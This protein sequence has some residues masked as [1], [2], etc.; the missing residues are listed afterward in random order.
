MERYSKSIYGDSRMRTFGKKQ[1]SPAD[2][3]GRASS[4]AEKSAGQDSWFRKNWCVLTLIA[5]VVVA[6]LLRFCFAYGISAGDNYALSGGSSAAS[7]RRIIAEILWGTYNPGNE[8]AL[9]Y[10]YGAESIYGPLF[11]Y[12]CAAW[13][14][15][16]SAFG[17]SYDASAGAALAW[18]PPIFGALT[19]IPV[20]ML[21]TKIFKGD[22]VIGLTAAG[23]YCLF[24]ALIMTSPFS[25]GTELPFL[26]FLVAGLTYFVVSA[27]SAVDELGVTGIK[28][29]FTTKAVLMWVLLAALFMVFIVLTWTG[30]WAIMMV[31]AIMLFFALL[32]ARL[33]GRPFGAVVGVAS[34]VLLAG[35]VAG[36][37]YYIPY[38]MWDSVFSG[39]CLVGVLAVAYSILF[40]ALEKKPWVLSIPLTCVVILAV[41]VVLYFVAPEL[42]DAALSG[43]DVY[44]GSLMSSLA[45]ETSRTSISAMAS[46]Y[47][48]LTLW[49]PLILG[50]WMFYKYR[51]N[52]RSNTYTFT[53]LWLLACYCVGWYNSEYA[54]VAGAGFAV[55]SAALI[56][57]VFRAV[58]LKSYFRSLRGNG[59][60]AGAKKA[61]NFFP[62]VT[63]LVAVLLVAVPTAVYAADA[64]TPSNDDGDGYFGG[65]G[66]TINTSDSSLVNSA[67]AHSNDY[68]TNDKTLLA[69]YGYSD[70]ASSAGG[71]STVT[72]SIGGGTSA[73]A[74]VFYATNGSE[75]I[76]SMLIRLIE[77]NPSAYKT[78]M[79]GAGLSD[80]DADAFIGILNSESKARAYMA[81]NPDKFVGYNASPA[82]ESLPYIVGSKFLESKLG[83]SKISEMYE[84]VCA[85][86]GKS[87]NYIEVDAGMI[88]LYYGDGS[89]ASSAAY[90]GDYKLD[91]YNAPSKFFN[92]SSTTEYY[93][94]YGYYDRMYYDYTD[95]MYDTFFWNAVMGVTP[96][97]YGLSSGINLLS[98]LASS[99]GSVVATPGAGMGHFKVVYWHLN[100]KA[101]ENA[102]WVDMDATAAFAKL[103]DEGGYVNFLSSV[104]VL[105]YVSGSSA[106]TVSVT[107]GSEKVANVKVAV[108]EKYDVSDAVSYVQ[109]STAYTDENGEC[110]IVLPAS[111]YLIRYYVGSEHLRDG[112]LVV[113]QS[114]YSAVDLAA[115]SIAGSLVNSD[116]KAIEN[117]NCTISFTDSSG[118]VKQ[119]VSVGTDGTFTGVSL[120]PDKYTVT[121]YS[122]D[123]A[124]VS[125]ESLYAVSTASDVRISA[126]TGSI[127]VSFVDMFGNTADNANITITDATG[128][129]VEYTA[130]QLTTLEGAIPVV[131]GTYTVDVS[132]ADLV[133]TGAKTV[134]VSSGSSSTQN[135]ELTVY[136]ATTKGAAGDFVMGIGYLGFLG[137]HNSVPALAADKLTVYND[138]TGAKTVSGTVKNN[139]SGTSATVVFISGTSTYVFSTGSDGSFSA[140]LPSGNYDLYVYNSAGRIYY[141][142]GLDASADVSD[143]AI[144][145]GE[146]RTVTF[147][148][149]YTTLMSPSTR[150]IAYVPIELH[151]T[152]DSKDY[153]MYPITGTDGTVKV[154]VPNNAE[155]Y[156]SIAEVT[157][158][159]ALVDKFN[160]DNTTKPWTDGTSSSAK[161][162]ITSS[163]SVNLK[164][165]GKETADKPY[166]EAVSAPTFK[167]SDGT[168]LPDAVYH[169]DAYASAGQDFYMKVESGSPTFYSDKECNTSI[170]TVLAGRYTVSVESG[171]AFVDSVTV[172]IYPTTTEVKFAAILADKI[173]FSTAAA[174]SVEVV[175]LSTNDTEGTTHSD[176]ETTSGITTYTYYVQKDT[177]YSYYFVVTNGTKI[178]YTDVYTGSADITDAIEPVEKKTLKGYVGS[179]I[180]GD[181]L[182]TFDTSKKALVK[183]SG[184]EY[185]VDLP[186]GDASVSVSSMILNASKDNANYTYSV[187]DAEL[188]SAALT[189]DADMTQNFAVKTTESAAGSYSITAASMDCDAGTGTATVKI[190]GGD[191]T[192]F[193]NGGNG[194]TLD[195]T[196]SITLNGADGNVDVSGFFNGASVGAGNSG[197]TLVITKLGSSDSTTLVIPAEYYINGAT[198][199]VTVFS[200]DDGEAKDSRN[201]FGYKYV[202]AFENENSAAVKIVFDKDETIANSTDFDAEKWILAFVDESGYLV[203]ADEYYVNGLT[204]T[205]LYAM[206]INKT[207]DGSEVPG[208]SINYKVGSDTTLIE[209]QVSGPQSGSVSVDSS[210][211]SGSGIDNS[212]STLPMG[213]WILLVFAV[214]LL[215]ISVWGGMKRGVFSRRN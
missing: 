83:E 163:T 198:G 105:E 177:A 137:D 122:A 41:A 151:V 21:A 160:W 195:K 168:A 138:S 146:G 169:F 82:S 47:G 15:L 99:D 202:L 148:V 79:T 117:S 100:Y 74:S 120:V 85:A 183:V 211:A 13:A 86:S 179:S 128:K 143:K 104:V 185:S 60:K 119:T 90:F 71:F 165:E 199:S 7:H 89:Y 62:L 125:S 52:I 69:W 55:G 53:M 50:L 93:Y 78:Q 197:M 189:V 56:V 94:Q 2:S 11:D 73:M 166:M 46:Y 190:T 27:F 10:P 34:A 95:D 54:I 70:S 101:S 208:L 153:T 191:G 63:V 154:Y 9:N 8:A 178:A 155:I 20:F 5:I 29:V 25:Y 30:F 92:V 111:D 58:D 182:V 131:A 91:K 80:E 149:N 209:K 48:W 106:T 3:E 51:E 130:A 102:S 140:K 114:S 134:T 152:A 124:S 98:S 210:S 68:A 59:A 214:L 170:T 61:L 6:F 113:T 75:A 42:S 133:S 187:T 22:K 192:Y 116:G 12:C 40:L 162:T 37:C 159:S 174:N 109:R 36:A 204:T 16:F 126:T 157:G 194:F 24:P 115:V 176:N 145:L 64:A 213:F 49:F 17:M 84:A 72:S 142:K 19:C 164:F 96:E 173:T 215:L 186:V 127:K 193:V 129:K 205:N 201:G 196:Y 171:N 180:D 44:I 32:F 28:E 45:A 136:K 118:K 172:N 141:E 1:T 203:D 87:I 147:T 167:N 158:D 112:T 57:M 81:E 103:K 135:A 184:G 23:F 76:A 156:Y 175:C 31:S 35:V 43:N 38:G 161:K 66:Y 26:C 14:K 123:G 33:A 108:F 65:M 67:W 121:V 132:A 97:T 139:G 188:L 77:S 144:A 18:N 110:D 107:S 206:L 4:P 39:G 212:E 207:N 181:I 200:A 88:P 150:G